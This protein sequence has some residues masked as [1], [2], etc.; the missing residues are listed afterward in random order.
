VRR[1]KGRERTPKSLVALELNEKCLDYFLQDDM[2]TVINC[3]SE[4]S[5]NRRK[6]IFLS[7][8]E[9]DIEKFTQRIPY[10]SGVA[11]LLKQDNT[12]EKRKEAMEAIM[13]QINRIIHQ[14]LPEN[15]V[16]IGTL[17][18]EKDLRD[19]PFRFGKVITP[20][21]FYIDSNPLAKLIIPEPEIPEDT[22]EKILSKVSKKNSPVKMEE[23]DNEEMPLDNIEE[24]LNNELEVTNK[25][26]EDSVR[27]DESI[28][29]YDLSNQPSHMVYYSKIKELSLKISK[30]LLSKLDKIKIQKPEFEETDD[31]GDYKAIDLENDSSRKA[32]ENK[33]FEDKLF[34]KVPF[35]DFSFQ[36]NVFN[37]GDLEKIQ[38]INKRI[39]DLN[40]EPDENDTNPIQKKVKDM[41]LLKI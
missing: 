12:E 30:K 7:S 40:F 1:K 27:D 21:E 10:L 13:A 38:R 19:Q 18:E 32:R 39:N 3:L 6:L 14:I 36:K 37:Q 34:A 29:E 31:S 2:E 11:I 28:N 4:I 17:F 33:K 24:D 23:I 5:K 26:L 41:C 25:S 16:Y 22:E 20:S 9:S 35:E 8:N 15:S